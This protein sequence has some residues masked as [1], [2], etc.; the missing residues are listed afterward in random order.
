M[1]ED[2]LMRLMLFCRENLALLSVLQPVV[3]ISEYLLALVMHLL[4][5]HISLY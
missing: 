3:C 2:I 1:F 4:V 5:M